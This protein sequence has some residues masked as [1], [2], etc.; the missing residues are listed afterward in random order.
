MAA[1][2]FVCVTFSEKPNNSICLYTI[3]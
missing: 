2:K 1:L 3:R